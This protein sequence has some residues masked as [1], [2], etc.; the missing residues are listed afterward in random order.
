MFVVGRCWSPYWLEDW[1]LKGLCVAASRI[2]RSSQPLGTEFDVR[3]TKEGPDF[4]FR[5]ASFREIENPRL[6]W[7]EGQGKTMAAFIASGISFRASFRKDGATEGRQRSAH[8]LIPKWMENVDLAS[9]AVNK[10]KI[11]LYSYVRPS[12]IIITDICLDDIEVDGHA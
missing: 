1:M 10:E 3:K 2:L 12:G 11:L 9:A 7:Y 5:L 4:H 8:V 6:L